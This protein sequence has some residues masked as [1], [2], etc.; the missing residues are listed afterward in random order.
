MDAF[1]AKVASEI[2]NPLILFLFALAIVFFLYGMLEFLLNQTSDEKK[3]TGRSHM[4]WGI[5]GIAIMMGVWT[6]LNIILNT[7]NIDYVDVD[8]GAIEVD[9]ERMQ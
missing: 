6:I 1:I 2:I 7:L 9:G 5:V 4:I 3:T 8:G